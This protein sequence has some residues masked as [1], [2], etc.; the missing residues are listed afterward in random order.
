MAGLALVVAVVSG[1]EIGAA[2]GKPLGQVLTS[3]IRS[4]PVDVSL[5]LTESW[6]RV[7]E[8]TGHQSGTGGIHFT[9]DD[10]PTLAPRAVA[11]TGPD[12]RQ[13]PTSGTGNSTETLTR[14]N[15][16]FTAAVSFMVSEPGSYRVRVDA[17]QPTQVI[18]G[19]SLGSGF[20]RVWG[21]FV[22]GGVAGLAVV[23]GLTML[24]VGLVLGRRPRP[25]AG[26]LLSGARMMPTTSPAPP[27]GW[28]PDPREP[29]RFRYWNGQAWTADTR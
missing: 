7:F 12:G 26:P 18:I 20:A 5:N 24:I 11:V 2:V 14:G 29:D 28:Y 16:I 27:A 21:W 13:V 4:T 9:R 25:V 19:P 6:Y 10:A 1:V 17:E 3:P 8:L 23:V 15:A 22:A